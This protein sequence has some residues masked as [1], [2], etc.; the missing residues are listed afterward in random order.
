MWN[1]IGQYIW[2]EHQAPG[3]LDLLKQAQTFGDTTTP[4]L[5]NTS[6][7]IFSYPF[8]TGGLFL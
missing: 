7:V 3:K 4:K 6:A 5:T 1:L 2:R 8:G